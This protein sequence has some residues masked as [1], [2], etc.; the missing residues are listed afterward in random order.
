MNYGTVI[1]DLGS[2]DAASL[3]PKAKCP[4]VLDD[5]TVVSAPGNEAG[6]LSPKR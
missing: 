1:G 2:F 6:S 3:C 4:T 5:K